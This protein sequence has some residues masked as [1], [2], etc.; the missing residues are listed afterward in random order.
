[1]TDDKRH[2]TDLF[3]YALTQLHVDDKGV[4]ASDFADLVV[5]AAMKPGRSRR[6]NERKATATVRSF[7]A[8]AAATPPPSPMS[9][10]PVFPHHPKHANS[11]SGGRARR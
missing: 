4:A 11:N 1:M 5:T 6:L 2:V 10:Y 8:A 3:E 9:I 7:C